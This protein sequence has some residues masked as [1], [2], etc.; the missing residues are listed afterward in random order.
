MGS[1]LYYIS[2]ISPSNDLIA[3]FNVCPFEASVSLSS[4]ELIWGSFMF[5]F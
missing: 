2:S 5:I 1:V 4:L 3:S